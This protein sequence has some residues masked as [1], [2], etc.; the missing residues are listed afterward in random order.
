MKR[1]YKSKLWSTNTSPQAKKFYEEIYKAFENELQ[2]VS[3]TILCQLS[4]NPSHPNG[5]ICSRPRKN[6][7]PKYLEIYHKPW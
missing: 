4:P 2:G 7:A 1:S 5:G 3:S 6:K